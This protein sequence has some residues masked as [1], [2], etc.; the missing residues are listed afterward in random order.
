MSEIKYTNVYYYQLFPNDEGLNPKEKDIF[1]KNCDKNIFTKKSGF[2][3][4][5]H[6]DG[7][8]NIFDLE[9][10]HNRYVLGTFVYNQT[11]NIPP[12]F[13]DIENKPSELK[14]GKFDG[15]GFDSSF[16]YDRKTRIIGLESKKPGTSQKSVE[17]FIMKNFDLTNCHLK[18]VVLPNEYNKF[19][20]SNKYTRLEMDLAIPNNDMGILKPSEKNANNI[21]QLMQD[22]KGTSAKIIISN[23]RSRKKTLSLENVRQLA[24]WLYKTDKKETL[25]QNLR[26]TGV[27]VD[28][29]NYH[30]FDLISNRLITKISIEKTRTIGSFQI[31]IKYDQLEGDFL[32]HRE[33]LEKLQ[34]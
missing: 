20:N 16:I 1:F 15:L 11:T 9:E 12:S 5:Q 10:R 26:I 8:V 27:D 17:D 32:A 3:R 21:L 34:K 2:T 31:K 7:Y 29:E 23:G 18:F 14:I 25:V 4:I 33:E 28:S 13:N 24:Q 6:S 22:L 19:L 30:I